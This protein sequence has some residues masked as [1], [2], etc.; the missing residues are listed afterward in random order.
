MKKLFALSSP[1]L[2]LL[3]G[4]KGLLFLI[5]VIAAL[6]RLGDLPTIPPGLYP[7]EAM[8]GNNALEALETRDW[9]VFYPE[10]NG[11][12]GLFINIQSFSVAMLGNEPWAL[13]LPSTI[14]GIL[15]VLGI[16][17]LTRELFREDKD[18]LA[19]ALLATFLLATSF[20]HINFSRIGFRAIMAP[21]FLTWGIYFLL[22]SL[23]K[24]TSIA[25]SASKNLKLGFGHWALPAL[26]GLVYGLGMHSYIAYRATPLLILFILI[27]YWLK[28]KN[29][30]VRKK[31]LLSSLFFILA[32]IIV[33]LPLGIHF[34]NNPADFFGRTTQVSVFA[35]EAPLKNLTLNT[36]KTLGMFNFAGD[37]NWRHNLAGQPQLFWPV[38]IMFLVGLLISLKYLIR[39]IRY[40]ML[41]AWLVVAAL[42][43]VISNEGMPHALR[44]IIMIPPVFI[45]SSIGGIAI[46]RFI[47]QRVRSAYA[48]KAASFILLL[49][50][51]LTAYYSY[52]IRW[53]NNPNTAGA[54]ASNYVEI[55]RELNGLPNEQPKY[56]IVNA[57]GA[58]VRGLPMP[59]QT[60]MFITNT[61]TPANQAQKNIH[62]LLPSQIEKVNIPAAAFIINL[63]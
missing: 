60:V 26:A 1:A 41:I 56:V 25:S 34:L 29:R 9:K 11:R 10:N 40:Q 8:N 28:N 6:L 43:V 53:A 2:N 51:L 39:D 50:I 55:G 42:P 12:E 61:F 62:Y 59:T 31:I 7:D 49:L 14:F 36:L 32:S 15:T 27:A 17:F 30:E 20:W 46:Y 24:I 52:F 58:D 4:P 47:A 13:R 44:A 5:I 37:Y 19:I 16:Y 23:H 38:G 35:S 3:K 21:F 57:G 22:M 48:L 18:G 54:F 45:L 63:Y 33:F